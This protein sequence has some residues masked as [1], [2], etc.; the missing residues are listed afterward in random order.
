MVHSEPLLSFW[1]SGILTY[2]WQ[3]VPTWSVPNKNPSCWVP[4]G[5]PWAEISACVGAF[6]LLG[7]KW[8]LSDQSWEEESKR[9]PTHISP[10]SA[11]VFSPLDLAVYP[12]YIIV[13][14][15]SH[16]YNYMLNSMNPS[17][18]PIMG[19][20]LETRDTATFHGDFISPGF[21]KQNWHNVFHQKVV[22]RLCLTHVMTR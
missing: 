5:F 3:R 22:E 18:S 6:L 20:V 9:K 13:I 21:K 15:I 10:D 11:C 7:D 2:D 12:Y 8:T 17:E 4:N 16:A 19:A 14:N 1:E